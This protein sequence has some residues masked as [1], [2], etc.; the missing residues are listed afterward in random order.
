VD[1]RE[2]DIQIGKG[3]PFPEITNGP[4]SDKSKKKVIL[5]VQNEVNH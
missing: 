2:T 5:I 4:W 1:L 3:M